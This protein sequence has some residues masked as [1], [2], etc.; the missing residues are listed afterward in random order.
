MRY[1]FS[2]ISSLWSVY[3]SEMHCACMASMDNV[4]ESLDHSS[5]YS[6]PVLTSHLG[7]SS[8]RGPFDTAPGAGYKY[9][10]EAL[11]C[12]A[13]VP[14]WTSRMYQLVGWLCTGTLALCP[15]KKG[16][17]RSFTLSCML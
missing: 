7:S 11:P 6:K 2:Q 13:G 14:I 8:G 3:P 16:D 15:V 10:E 9:L 1:R 4:S 5:S 17:K 12:Q